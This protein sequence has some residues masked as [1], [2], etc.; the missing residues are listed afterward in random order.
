M[1]DALGIEI[2]NDKKYSSSK[3]IPKGI[4]ID[5]KCMYL[6]CESI[7]LRY[8]GVKQVVGNCHGNQYVV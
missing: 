6:H 3:S 5:R 7:S 8:K 4:A 1:K 2:L